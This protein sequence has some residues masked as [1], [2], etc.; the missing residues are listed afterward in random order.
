MRTIAAFPLRVML[1]TL[2]GLLFV[3][4][5]V[6]AAFALL[7]DKVEGKPAHRAERTFRLKA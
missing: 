4:G 6:F 3:L 2:F 1:W 5:A 7:L